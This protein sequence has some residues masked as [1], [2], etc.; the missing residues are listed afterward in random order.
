MN[1]PDVEFSVDGYDGNERVF[2]TFDEAAGFAVSVAASGKEDVAIDVLIWSENGA[3]A[4]AGD[5]GIEMYLEDPE[6]SVFERL[7]IKVNSV[8]RVP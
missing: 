7:E 2:K 8:G 5:D 4:Y 3:R 6:A 1:H